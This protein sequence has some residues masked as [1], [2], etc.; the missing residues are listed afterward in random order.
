MR[1]RPLLALSLCTL[2]S[3]GAAA[4]PA[5]LEYVEAESGWVI[6]KASRP[7]GYRSKTDGANIIFIVGDVTLGPDAKDQEGSG[8]MVQSIAVSPFDDGGVPSALVR[9][10]LD[11]ERSYAAAW[12]ENELT[13]ELQDPVPGAI[14]VPK[15]PV[16][17]KA[18]KPAAPKAS[19]AAL[20]RDSARSAA[21][22][23]GFRVQL[24]SFPSEAQAAK[25]KAELGADLG[26][27]EVVRAVAAGKV[28][29]R[30]TLGPFP[31]R[32]AAK[33][34]LDKASAGGRDGIIIRD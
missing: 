34:A 4:E 16:K 32:A 13:V 30:A 5:V 7:V 25:F 14:P 19:E 10:H 15:A 2:L 31:D 3:V 20:P 8:G 22:G 11:I 23:K 1:T 17:A 18:A 33:A 6:L 27:S 24:A 26:A 21:A 29:Y 12:K 9:I 28:V